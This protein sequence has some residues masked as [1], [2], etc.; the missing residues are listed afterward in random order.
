MDSKKCGVHPPLRGLLSIGLMV[1]LSG[2]YH[3]RLTAS[4]G[5]LM[6]S[7]FPATLNSSRVVP[8]LPLPPPPR[9]CSTNGL[10]QVQV[11]TTY[12]HALLTVFTFG[13]W[14]QVEVKYWCAAPA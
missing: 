3:V 11:E 2:C 10:D 12:G 6:T 14:S 7:G 8:P 9:D 4:G 5:P 13:G 1:A